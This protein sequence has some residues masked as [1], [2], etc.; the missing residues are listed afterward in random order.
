MPEKALEIARNLQLAKIPV[1]GGW[2]AWSAFG[3]CSKTSI[4]CGGGI[5]SRRRACINPAPMY[6]GRTC[7]GQ[8]VDTRRCNSKICGKPSKAETKFSQPDTVLIN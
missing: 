3:P 2:G 4:T 5:Q 1:D 6:G 8:F 7:L